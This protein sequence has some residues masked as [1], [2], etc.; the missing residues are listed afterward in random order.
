MTQGLEEDGFYRFF[1]KKKKTMGT[2]L[3]TPFVAVA[4]GRE[5]RTTPQP[6]VPCLP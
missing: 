3:V 5:K 6:P 2:T 1:Y 4:V